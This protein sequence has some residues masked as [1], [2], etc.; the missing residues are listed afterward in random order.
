MLADPSFLH[1]LLLEQ[2]TTIGCS[3]WLEFKNR[4]DKIK[5][6]W[7]LALVY[8]LTVAACDAIFV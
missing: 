6:E 2:A 7:D 4:K 1:K 5:L 8:V 3:V